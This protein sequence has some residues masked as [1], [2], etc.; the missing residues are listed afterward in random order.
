MTGRSRGPPRYI[1]QTG[2]EN[3]S[4]PTPVGAATTVGEGV[5]E[6]RYEDFEIVENHRSRA[7]TLL[8]GGSRKGPG[9]GAAKEG[10][11]DFGVGDPASGAG[12]E[13][14][15]PAE[16]KA[17]VPLSELVFRNG[18]GVRGIGEIWRGLAR[19]RP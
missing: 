6:R 4:G 3:R 5:G 19:E 2:N 13:G 14:Y 18:I 15:L 11:F 1:H 16:I 7:R 9:R 17:R 10:G 8:D 12:D